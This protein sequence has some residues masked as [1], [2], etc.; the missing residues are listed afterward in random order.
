MLN[1]ELFHGTTIERVRSI[2][3]KGL[4]KSSFVS[5][6]R[7]VAE[8][9]AVCRQKWNRQCAVILTVKGKTSKFRRDRFGRIEAILLETGKILK[10]EPIGR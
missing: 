8:Y 6:D 4:N 1:V 5:P 7:K 9:F 2:R 10:I 3:T